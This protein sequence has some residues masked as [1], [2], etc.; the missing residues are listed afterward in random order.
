VSSRTFQT[1]LVF[2]IEVGAVASNTDSFVGV[3]PAA[4]TYIAYDF[5]SPFCLKHILNH[6]QFKTK[7]NLYFWHALAHTGR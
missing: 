4:V 2:E 6:Y 7:I 5:V 3:V 1:A